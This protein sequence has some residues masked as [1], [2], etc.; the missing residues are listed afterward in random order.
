MP[1][2]S[3]TYR[4]QKI[5]AAIAYKRGDR[6]EAYKLWSQS[7]QNTHEHLKKKQFKK[8]KAAEEA[9]AKEAEEKAKASAE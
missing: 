5:N 3:K 4:R 6:E 1:R 8:K 7:A 9:A 2:P